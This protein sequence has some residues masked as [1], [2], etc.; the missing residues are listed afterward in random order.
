MAL[1][2]VRAHFLNKP[3]VPLTSH[4]DGP[5]D[6]A[7]RLRLIATATSGHAT[8]VTLEHDGSNTWA[9][10]KTLVIA[11]GSPR[12]LARG[13]FVLDAKSGARCPADRRGLATV[14]EGE[15]E[16]ADSERK[17]VWISAGAKG[18]RTVL[19]INGERIA[20]VDWG[21]KTGTVEHVEVVG[22]LGEH[23]TERSCRILLNSG[24]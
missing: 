14:L 9:V 20:K 24:V 7:P 23:F 19:N 3:V 16:S 13:S 11:E 18:V 4:D 2:Q 5:A 10:S 8:I 17:Y 12:P 1:L 21:G 22:R 15:S 6:P